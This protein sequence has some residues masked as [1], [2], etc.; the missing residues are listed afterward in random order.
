MIEPRDFLEVAEALARGDSEAEWRSAISR[1]YYAAFHG[2]RRLLMNCGFVVPRADRAHAFLWMRLA[3]SGD[4]AIQQAGGWLDSLRGQRNEGDYDLGASFSAA[5]ARL[6]VQLGK[7]ILDVL[8][9]AAA[10]PARITITEAMKT[11]ERD[12]LKDVTWRPR[13][14]TS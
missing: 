12:V 1:A 9:T 10:D 7:A 13:R 4:P 6:H 8:D 11:Y 3:N 2:A 14:G 5:T